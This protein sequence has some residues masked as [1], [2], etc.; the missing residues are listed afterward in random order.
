MIATLSSVIF[1]CASVFA[2]FWL[3]TQMN[4]EAVTSSSS[5][6]SYT[7]IEIKSVKKD[8]EDILADKEKHADIP[9]QA[10]TSKMGKD[11][12]FTP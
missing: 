10:V 7:Q 6:S 2:F 4:K 9:V 8:A 12:P 11:N 1:A 3:W 5:S